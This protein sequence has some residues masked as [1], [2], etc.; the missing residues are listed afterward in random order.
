MY[1]IDRFGPVVRIRMAPTFLGRP[2]LWV[3]AFWVAGLLIDSGCRHTVPDLLQAIEQEG[4]R[5]EQLVHT[6]TDE[7]HIA[8]TAELVRR[9]GVRPRVHA[10]GLKG[11][12]IPETKK[13]LQLYR[14]FFWGAAEPSRGEALGDFVEAG[15]YRF[16]VIHT[17]GHARDHIALWEEREGWLFSGDLM[18]S[19]RHDRVRSVE[20]PAVALE[21][22]RTLAALP[23]RQLFCS[24]AWRVHESAEPLKHK[25]TFWERL[26]QDAAGLQS[27][28]LSVREITRRL[29]GKNGFM[30]WATLGDVSKQNLVNGLLRAVGDPQR[31]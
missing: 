21:S 22:M 2:L 14:R 11:L 6:H 19:P 29:L 26:R 30:E 28:G 27:Q 3:N 24:H 13:E 31:L 5:V 9:F 25:V 10:L 23:V 17:P 18:L 15:T 20:E 16:E 8:G 1:Q 12:T 4:L 7:D